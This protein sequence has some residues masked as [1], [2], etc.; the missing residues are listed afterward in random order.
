VATVA[1]D[2]FQF[3]VLYV[4]DEPQ[5]LV[6]FRYALEGRFN[7]MTAASGSEALATLE[8][9]QVA[10]LLCD[11]RMPGME[12]AEVCSRA[13]AIRPEAVRIIV[14]AYADLQAAIDAINHGQVMR[15]L[16]KPWRN[17][18][19]EV[20]L[21]TSIELVHLR[22]VL[23]D[24]QTR[25]MR[26]GQSAA[27][28]SVHDE[29]AR[30][31][32]DPV[33]MLD[34]NADQL[35]DLLD[36]SVMSWDDPKRARVLVE[37]ARRAQGET[38]I[39]LARLSAILDRLR[40]HQRL[41]PREPPPSTD[42]TRA[43]QSMLPY[44]GQLVGEASRLKV[45]L[46][47]API[48][49]IHT[50][51]LAQVVANLVSNAARASLAVPEVDDTVVVAVGETAHDAVISVKDSGR[52]VATEQLERIFDPHFTTWDG[53]GLGLAVSRSLVRDAGGS[54]KVESQPGD[55]TRFVISVPRLT[56]MG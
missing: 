38:R 23:R 40:S 19:L 47:A 48:A 1:V 3:P 22:Q 43:I 36:A 17:D 8:R 46:D 33:A 54:I 18:E 10:V 35:R 51:D 21:R 15:Y 13:R 9:E 29:I 31:L 20:L 12:G 52:G 26:G 24:M 5:N 34:I 39:P 49:Q 6:T 37:E 55:G 4:D 32:Q 14:T 7:V 27:I 11:Q 41:D 42:V 16:T 28:D 53:S 50:A 30:Q 45:V 25:L 44:L 2:L 56:T